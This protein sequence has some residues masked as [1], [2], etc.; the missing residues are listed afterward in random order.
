[1]SRF[2]AVAL[3]IAPIAIATPTNTLAG[4]T[5]A[6]ERKIIASKPCSKVRVE[7]R[8]LGFKTAIGV[9]KFVDFDISDFE[10]R[11][12]EDSATLRTTM[13]LRCKTSD[14]AVVK[15]DVSATLSVD[16]AARL[17]NCGI[18]KNVARI[19]RTGGTFGG[20][21]RFF[22]SA[23]ENEI[24]STIAKEIGRLCRAIAS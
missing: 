17:N 19:T 23:L 15:G 18:T 1:M 24:Q 9:D 2:V 22:R 20:L 12:T 10:V 3:C 5:S 4:G 7:K 16:A 11:A 8:I 6:L 21:V 13:T 14:A